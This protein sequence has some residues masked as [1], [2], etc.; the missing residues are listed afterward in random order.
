MDMRFMSVDMPTLKCTDSPEGCPCTGIGEIRTKPRE[1][2]RTLAAG[3]H[4]GRG[5]DRGGDRSARQDSA[6]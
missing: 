1:L 6:E 3:H 5:D 4:N 2:L